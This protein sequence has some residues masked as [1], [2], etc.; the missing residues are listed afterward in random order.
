MSSSKKVLVAT[1]SV[2]DV[3]E[4][5]NGI[6][7]NA[8]NVNW[9]VKWSTLYIS[10]DDGPMIEIEPSIPASESSDFKR[11]DSEAVEDAKN[12]GLVE[13]EEEEEVVPIRIPE[14]A[15]ETFREEYRKT[16][17]Y[18]ELSKEMEETEVE[19]RCRRV[20]KYIRIGLPMTEAMRNA[21]VE[22]CAM[23]CVDA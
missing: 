5:P 7:L 17:E 18:A 23:G 20:Y 21:N 9:Y 22:E 13:E 8:P 10:V 19:E 15:Y 6:D 14:T 12:W 16:E 4:I 2:Q 11:P 3:F 1:Y